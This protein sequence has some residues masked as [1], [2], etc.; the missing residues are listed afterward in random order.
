MLLKGGGITNQND[1]FQSCRVLLLRFLSAE[2]G[3]HHGR[4]THITCKRTHAR[5][6]GGRP[7]PNG[8]FDNIDVFNVVVVDGFDNLAVQAQ[9]VSVRARDWLGDDLR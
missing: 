2:C 8:Q 1:V 3:A 6:T 5:K 9:A 4:G 7:P